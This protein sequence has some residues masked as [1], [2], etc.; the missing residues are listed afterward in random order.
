MSGEKSARYEAKTM[1]VL[2]SDRGLKI[3]RNALQCA[4]RPEAALMCVANVATRMIVAE[5]LEAIALPLLDKPK[6]RGRLRQ[7]GYTIKFRV[8]AEFS[9]EVAG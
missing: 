7:A 4:M 5:R 6:V 9:M 8:E 2:M 1:Q 3:A